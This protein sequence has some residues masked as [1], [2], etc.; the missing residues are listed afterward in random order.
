MSEKPELPEIGEKETGLAQAAPLLIGWFK[1]NARPLPWRMDRDPYRILVSETMLQQT[2]IETVLPYFE[3]FLSDYPDPAHLAAAPE[4]E[5]LKHW[6]GLGY[7]SRARHLREAARQCVEKY[8]GKLPGSYAGLRALPGL[9]EYTAGAVASLAYGEPVSAVDGNVLRVLS[10][11]WND[12]RDISRSAVKKEARSRIEAVLRTLDEPGVF[13]E[14]LM[15]LG[16]VR[17]LPNGRPQCLRCPLNGLCLA[18]QAGTEADLPNRGEIKPRRKEAKTVLLLFCG[19]KVAL[20][21]RPDRG[22]LAGLYGFPMLDGALSLFD[23]AEWVRSF[24]VRVLSAEPAGEAVHVFTHVEWAMRG[25]RFRTDRPLPGLIY[26]EADEL[27]TKYA[28]PSAFRLYRAQAKDSGKD[29]Q[30]GKMGSDQ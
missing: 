23:A 8:G 26:A 9:G 22:L 21:K 30:N 6:E 3:R 13:N 20:E 19:E 14:A 2:R 28:L 16:E 15:E 10:R 11:F 24:G 7:Y 25:C 27:A 29:K 18:R 5:V 12:E 17:C 1:K 4:D